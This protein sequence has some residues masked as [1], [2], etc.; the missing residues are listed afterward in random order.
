MFDRAHISSIFSVF[1]QCI[2]SVLGGHISDS[3]WKCAAWHGQ[4]LNA[5]PLLI[6]CIWKQNTNLLS[7][8]PTYCDEKPFLTDTDLDAPVCPSLILK[9]SY[10]KCFFFDLNCN[11]YFF[12]WMVLNLDVIGVSSKQKENLK[13]CCQPVQ[14]SIVKVRRVRWG[15]WHKSK[16]W[17]GVSE[18]GYGKEH[19]VQRD[20][21][22]RAVC[23]LC[24]YIVTL[25]KRVIV[26]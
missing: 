12:S 26:L 8:H 11:E 10:Q 22:N 17:T 25:A 15:G 16:G 5:R 14:V 9:K 23:S 2:W 20:I 1:C 18:K 21:P 4:S 7:W 19:F 13:H 3:E 6:V 24:Y